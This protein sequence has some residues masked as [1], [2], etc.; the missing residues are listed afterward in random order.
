MAL[1]AYALF[2]RHVLVLVYETGF[3]VAFETEVRDLLLKEPLCL[4]RVGLVTHRAE[5]VFNR[6]MN[7]FAFHEIDLLMAFEAEVREINYKK[8]RII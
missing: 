1:Q 6:R 3:P 2:Y 7:D 4:A 8:S 5:L